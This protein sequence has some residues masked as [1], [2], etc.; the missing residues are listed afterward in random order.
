MSEQEINMWIKTDTIM[1]NHPKTLRLAAKLGLSRRETVGLLIDFFVWTRSYAETGFLAEWTNEDICPAIGLPDIN[2]LEIL[3]EVGWMDRGRIKNWS[4]FGG[5]EITEKAKR[6][7][8]QYKKM[9]EFYSIIPYGENTGEIREKNGLDKKRRDKKRED[10]K[11]TIPAGF[12]EWYTVYPRKQ[13]RQEAEEAWRQL[14]PNAELQATMK[15]VIPAQIKGHEWWKDDKKQFIPLPAS[16]I[17]AK[18]WTDQFQ[19]VREAPKRTPRSM[20][21]L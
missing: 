7:P 9:I 1:P 2:L 5:S 21:D 11:D 15:A 13:K 18:R 8:I 19:Q 14:D 12:E 16:W 4:V 3:Q 20:D 10:K 17:R 6:E